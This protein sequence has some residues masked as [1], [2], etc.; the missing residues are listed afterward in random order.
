MH[1]VMTQVFAAINHRLSEEYT[2]I[3]LPSLEAKERCVL[4]YLYPDCGPAAADPCVHHVLSGYS[5]TRAIYR[6]SSRKAVIALWLCLTPS[7]RRSMQRSLP[8]PS[9]LQEHS[10]TSSQFRGMFA[11]AAGRTAVVAS[12]QTRHLE[13]APDAD[14]IAILLAL[15]GPRSLVDSRDSAD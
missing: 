8:Q 9:H 5:R 12:A 10:P 2:K 3:E 11:R 6:R 14:R 1:Y 7:C 4:T 13:K 15:V